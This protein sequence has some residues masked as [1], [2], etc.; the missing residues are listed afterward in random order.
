MTQAAEA[1]KSESPEK[2]APPHWSPKLIDELKYAAGNGVVGSRLVSQT[3]RVRVWNIQLQPGERLP[4]HCHV[5]DYF[6]TALTPGCA[7]SRLADGSVAVVEYKVGDTQHFQYGARQSRIHD[8]ENIGDAVLAF[9][10]V[11][12][13]YSANQPLPLPEP[14]H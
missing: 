3:E 6:W 1:T 8:L 11:E 12:F 4:F 9:T 10:T 5:L 7:R 2:F 14:A 13:L